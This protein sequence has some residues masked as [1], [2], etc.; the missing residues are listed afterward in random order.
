MVASALMLGLM[1]FIGIIVFRP[2]DASCA[3]DAAQAASGND[4]D[5]QVALDAWTRMWAEFDKEGL[6]ALDPNLRVA[7]ARFAGDTCGMRYRRLYRGVDHAI[8]EQLAIAAFANDPD[9]KQRI[10]RQSLSESSNAQIRARIAVELARVAAR[11]GDSV[12]AEAALRQAAEQALPPPCEAD[13]HYLQGRIALHRG[14]PRE[15]L[16]ALAAATALDPGYWN[17]WRD[18]IPALIRLLREPGMRPADCLDRTRRLIRA[19]GLLPQLADDTRQFS[20]LALSLERHD[21]HRSAT[22]L[23]LGLTWSWAGQEQY[24]RGV[25]F[26]ALEAPEALPDVCEHAIRSRVTAVLE[27]T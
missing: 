12:A 5:L 1:L 16:E 9:T 3:D 13:I 11:R 27:G 17:A 7:G 22:L 10:L 19:L 20:M 14:N 6:S 15:A 4:T 21:P 18:Q 23:A 24:A 2:P 25:L 8:R 26:R